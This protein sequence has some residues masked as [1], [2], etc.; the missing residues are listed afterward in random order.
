MYAMEDTDTDKVSDFILNFYH[1]SKLLQPERAA[2]PPSK[3]KPF[4]K[5]ANTKVLAQ[6]GRDAGLN[7]ANAGAKTG[8]SKTAAVHRTAVEKF[9][10]FRTA[11]SARLAERQKMDHELRMELARNK[12]L[13]YQFKKQDNDAERTTR[14][15]NS[16][17]KLSLHALTPLPS[18]QLLPCPLLLC[19]QLLL[20]L[21]F[22]G[23]DT[24]PLPS[25]SSPSGSGI[26]YT[27]MSSG[28]S[29]SPFSSSASADSPMQRQPLSAYNMQ[30]TQSTSNFGAFDGGLDNDDMFK[31][32]IY[33]QSNF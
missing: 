4:P 8:P 3:P 14:L 29:L 12:R 25:N 26:P 31:T 17:S 11:E 28:S 13:K 20:P 33:G 32:G 21:S 10:D 22:L 16:A 18:C 24:M 19:L 27:P 2:S 23:T 9:N 7:K 30:D 15:R 6:G 5:L 1:Y